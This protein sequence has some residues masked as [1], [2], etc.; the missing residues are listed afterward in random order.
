M[1]RRLAL[2]LSLSVLVFVPT[3]HG[4]FPG[5]NGKIIYTLQPSSAP[6][7]LALVDPATLITTGFLPDPNF[8][9]LHASWSPDGTRVLTIRSAQSGSDT[10]EHIWVA[11]ADGSGARQVTFGTGEVDPAWSPDGHTIVFVGSDALYTVNVDNPSDTPH[12]IPGTD[13]SSEAPAWSPD[14]ALI[15]YSHIPPGNWEIDVIAPDG[16]GEHAI[17]TAPSGSLQEIEP[18]WSP[19]GSRVYYAQGAFIVGCHAS[20][21]FQIFSVPRAGGTPVPFSKDPSVSEYGPAPS[22]DGKQIAFARCDDPTGG[23]DH[24]YV[25][26]LDGSGAHAVSSGDHYD[27]FPSW[28]PAAPQI[29]SPPTISGN[30]VN[31]QTLTAS[32]GTSGGST[33]TTLQFE[34]CNA[35]GAA[36]API[37]GASASR[38]HA[39]AASVSY[40]LTSVDLGHAIRVHEVDTNPLGTSTAD[41][42][43]TKAVVPSPGH[44]SNR[45]AGTAKADRIKGSSGSDRIVGGAGRDKLFG[46]G[47]ADC[48]SGGAGNDTISGGKGNDTLSGG[49]GNDKIT[50]G[51]GRNKVSGG[52]GND[53]ISVRNHKRDIVNCGPGKDR[54]TADKIDK[55]RGC[56]RV[57]RKK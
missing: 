17:V 22:P 24:I 25:A 34:R 52:P 26:N 1:I 9:D 39:A 32:A 45:F 38:A 53:T 48:I 10:S 2:A 44:C 56:E 28:Q 19:D 40:K 6:R 21:P 15:A 8:D 18:A 12:K 37:P 4:A 14:G 54:V 23:D 13:S 49:V 36:C 50:A 29:S 3:A 27:N 31:N 51:P 11:N 35:Q 41:S 47:G 43:P 33:S 30:G 7:A 5:G 57:K 20:P 16:S 42:A 46:L 55:L